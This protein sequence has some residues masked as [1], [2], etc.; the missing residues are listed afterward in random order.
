M[1]FWHVGLNMLVLWSFAP[2]LL[3]TSTQSNW[4]LHVHVLLLFSLMFIGDASPYSGNLGDSHIPLH[5]WSYYIT[6]GERFFGFNLQFHN[7][8]TAYDIKLNCFYLCI[9]Y[10]V[11]SRCVCIHGWT[12][13]TGHQS[14]ST[15]ITR[16]REELPDLC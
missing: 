13:C 12:L 7:K 8:S 16:S 6:G 4:R 9:N 2:S 5:S 14:V 11:P 15:G 1:E 10:I 3:R